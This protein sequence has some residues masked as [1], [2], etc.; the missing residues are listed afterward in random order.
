MQGEKQ[1]YCEDADAKLEGTSCIKVIKGEITGYTCPTG[2]N[3]NGDKCTK[4]STETIDATANTSK[5][6]S[7]KYKWSTSSKLDG[8]EFTGKTKVVEE[9][10]TAGQK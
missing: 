2:Y 4:I 9:T 7:Y 5:T 1:Y 3:Q 8:W 10:Y 6:K